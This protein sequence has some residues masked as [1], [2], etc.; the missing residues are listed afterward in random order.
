MQSGRAVLYCHDFQKEFIEPK[1]RALI[2]SIIFVYNISH[3]ENNLERY[4][5]KVR[6]TPC[7]VR[8]ALVIF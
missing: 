2:F 1:I 5:H 3:S 6:R 7:E 4:Y 8:N